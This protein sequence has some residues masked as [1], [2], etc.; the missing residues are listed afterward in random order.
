MKKKIKKTRKAKKIV[1][2]LI[3]EKGSGKG[4][5][6]D[7]LIKNYGAAHYST[8]RILKRTIESLHLPST[9][10]NYIKLALVLK[11]A[12]WSSVVID[13]LIRDIE[14]SDAKIVIAD[15]IRM[16]GDV[17][18][19]RKKYGKNFFLIYVTADL[20]TRY[21]RT[22]KRKEKAGEDKTTL[23]Q[24]ILEE[25]GLTEV[26]IHE[27]GKKADFIFDNNGTKK[28][29]EAQTEKVAKKILKK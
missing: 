29:L 16:H 28:E 5:V 3:G 13:A 26:S 4:T 8:S 10:E 11:D 22:K 1:I 14:E 20:K 7:Y 25:G 24:F 6:S 19:F 23:K 27:I 15:G 18:P 2:G 21:E 12:F 17:E 9:R